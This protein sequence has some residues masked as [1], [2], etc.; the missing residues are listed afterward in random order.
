VFVKGR[1]VG[2]SGGVKSNPNG[3]RN[4]RPAQTDPRRDRPRS[5]GYTHLSYQEMMDR[6]EKSLC[7]KCKAPFH[8][9]HQCPNRQL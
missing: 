6:K 1:E 3:P 2:S 5:R 8:P 4:D 9:M 7:F